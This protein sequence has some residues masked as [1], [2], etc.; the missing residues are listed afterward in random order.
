MTLRGSGFA[1]TV[2]VC[3][4]LL[5]RLCEVHERS[6]VGSPLLLNLSASSST[7]LV[8][9]VGSDNRR[10]CPTRLDSRVLVP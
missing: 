5:P 8:V 10:C 1:R 3:S 4:A 9:F 6:D 7:T 2:L